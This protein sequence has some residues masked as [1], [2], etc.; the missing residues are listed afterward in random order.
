MIHG[1]ELW[2]S[3]GTEAGTVL[4]KDMSAGQNSTDMEHLTAAN[5]ILY[6]IAYQEAYGY[7]LWRSDGTAEGTH[8]VKDLLP[9]AG[10]SM[11]SFYSS[12]YSTLTNVGGQ[13]FFV[14]TDIDIYNNMIADAYH[15][16]PLWGGVMG[17]RLFQLHAP[18]LCSIRHSS[19]IE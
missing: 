17:A 12:R 13:L 19:S 4:V 2:R 10:S 6:F 14:A 5:N 8:M 15:G 16:W 9:G 1:R 11:L 7:E 3:D 18:R